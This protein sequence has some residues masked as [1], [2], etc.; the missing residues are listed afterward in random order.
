MREPNFEAFDRKEYMYE[1]WKERRPVCEGCGNPIEDEYE[2]I[3]DGMTF[4]EDCAEEH[5]YQCRKL[6]MD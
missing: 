5:V 6:I 1:K 3:L 4:C 2:Y